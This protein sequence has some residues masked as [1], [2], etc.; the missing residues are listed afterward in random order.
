MRDLTDLND[1]VFAASRARARVVQAK[2]SELTAHRRAA[3]M[4][5][6]AAELQ[7]RHGH[8][9]RA[10]AALQRADHARELHDLALTEL[11]EWGLLP[12]SPA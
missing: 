5:E 10:Q 6:Q 9:A 12:I 3:A 7:Q 1:P 4:H 2:H 11:A 8:E